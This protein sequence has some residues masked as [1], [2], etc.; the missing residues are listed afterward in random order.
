MKNVII[1]S[2]SE[3]ASSQTIGYQSAL[4]G[5][6]SEHMN[7]HAPTRRQMLANMT[8]LQMSTLTGI[9]AMFENASRDLMHAAIVN[10]HPEAAD[11]LVLNIADDA[12]QTRNAALGTVAAALAKDTDVAHARMREF[13][14]K[15]ELL[16][17]A[18]G[19][20]YSSAVVH[21]GLQERQR[22]ITFG[23]LD[24]LGRKWKSSQFVAATLRGALQHI[25]ADA[26]VRAASA[27]GDTGVVLQYADPAHD[28]HGG[29][30][31]MSDYLDVRNE[32]FHP[33]SRAML[34]RVGA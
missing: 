14:L 9:T 29:V 28:G 21:A 15:V 6:V 8:R 27:R 34:A 25:Y 17:G 10:A 32:L 19:R 31:A 11:E 4:A 33:N 18:G 20:S 7:P 12:L 3:F 2:F 24:S 30:I 26:F 22:G 1:D 13:G 16:V 5:L 23:Q